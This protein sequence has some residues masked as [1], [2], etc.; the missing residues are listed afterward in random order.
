MRPRG[1]FGS[2]A[3]SGHPVREEGWSRLRVAGRRQHGQFWRLRLVR[4]ALS[5]PHRHLLAGPHVRCRTWPALRSALCG[6][7]EG[8]RT[9]SA[10]HWDH[11]TPRR[12]A[13]PNT[14]DHR[15]SGPSERAV[16]SRV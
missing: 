10:D 7:F 4:A 2:G 9:L 13:W 3:A 5:E 14:W 12:S 1:F 8:W 6:R 15:I 11:S 16:G